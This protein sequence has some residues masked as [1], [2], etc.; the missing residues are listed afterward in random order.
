LVEQ[1]GGTV[2]ARSEGAG[3]GSCFTVRLPLIAPPP[4][5]AEV[6]PS[7]KTPA[8]GAVPVVIVDDNVDAA[9]TLGDAMEMLGYQPM[10][11]HS[12][13]HAL[14]AMEAALPRAAVLDIGLPDMNGY[15][16][17]KKIRSE[18]WGAGMVLVAATGWG[19]ASDKQAA[20][21]AGFDLHFT[22]PLDFI[23]LDKQLRA[24]LTQ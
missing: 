6:L 23:E 14:Q 9:E 21:D 3:K 24:I 1:H 19:Q 15:E 13:S 7:L 18:P 22:K 10:I 2:A 20:K 4:A 16:L 12:G 11:A 8:A 17:A 5:L